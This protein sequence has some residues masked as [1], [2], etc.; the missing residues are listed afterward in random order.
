MTP[1]SFAKII[2]MY[3][4]EPQASLLNGIIF[5]IQLTTSKDFYEALKQ[6]G[7]LHIVVLS[8][9]NITLLSSVVSSFFNIF[10]LDIYHV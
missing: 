4:S 7:L 9:I 2:R 1:E 3:M 5:G 8:G 6:V 10:W